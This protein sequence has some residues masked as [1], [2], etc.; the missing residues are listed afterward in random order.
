MTWLGALSLALA[1]YGVIVLLEWV[2]ARLLARPEWAAQ[3]AGLSIVLRA[4]DAEAWVEDVVRRIGRLL[5]GA[6][7]EPP[8]FLQV[9]VS[10]AD[11]TDQT[12][13]IL[14]RLCRDYRF[15]GWVEPGLEPADVLAQ[16]RHRAVLWLEVSPRTSPTGVAAMVEAVLGALLR[17]RVQA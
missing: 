16:C 8:E 17:S 14:E 3:A 1:L 6:P 13:P 7:G 5:P 11:S 10:E 12:L 15:L 9:L 2:Y 4:T